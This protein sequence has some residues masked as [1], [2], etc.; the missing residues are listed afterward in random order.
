VKKYTQA[1]SRK[2]HTS[3]K[4]LKANIAKGKVYK[5]M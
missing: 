5:N 1:F 4:K 3:P 2:G